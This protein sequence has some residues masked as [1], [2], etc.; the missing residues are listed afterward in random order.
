MIIC[1][2][3]AVPPSIDL[4]LSGRQFATGKIA[5]LSLLFA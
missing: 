3:A 1:Y 2:K 5:S 4:K